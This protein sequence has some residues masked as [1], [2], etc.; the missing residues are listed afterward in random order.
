MFYSLLSIGGAFIGA[1][2]SHHLW[3]TYY[4]TPLKMTLEECQAF[5]KE[6]DRKK[7]KM[8]VDGCGSI[9]RDYE[10][11]LIA[12]SKEETNAFM[13]MN[14]Q[15]MS[16]MTDLEREIF[17][18]KYFRMLQESIDEKYKKMKRAH[19]NSQIYVKLIRDGHVDFGWAYDTFSDLDLSVIEKLDDDTFEIMLYTKSSEPL[20]GKMTIYK[21]YVSLRDLENN[22]RDTVIA[23]EGYMAY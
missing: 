23:G 6:H 4:G 16:N 15:K 8:I 22:S 12:M 2:V 10:N 9:A 20:T 7:W 14:E 13:G 11:N 17:K 3:A 18:K 1:V 21:N 5:I 19:E